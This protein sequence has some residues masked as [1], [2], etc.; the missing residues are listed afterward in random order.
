MQRKSQFNILETIGAFLSPREKPKVL[1]EKERCTHAFPHEGGEGW[2]REVCE[3]D[4]FF[5]GSYLSLSVIPASRC[6]WALRAIPGSLIFSSLA[7]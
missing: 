4:M 5:Y 2:Q 7:R 3:G 6:W 1:A